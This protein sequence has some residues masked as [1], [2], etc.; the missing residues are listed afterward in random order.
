MGWDG[1]EGGKVW[2]IGDGWMAY[3]S[4]D[5]Y[6]RFLIPNYEY[7]LYVFNSKWPES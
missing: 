6:S 5:S 3:D 7:Q 1:E 2:F 4:L